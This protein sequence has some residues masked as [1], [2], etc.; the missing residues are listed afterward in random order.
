MIANRS[1]KWNAE[2]IA[3]IHDAP[4]SMGQTIGSLSKRHT[5]DIMELEARIKSLIAENKVM[6]FSK[7]YCPY[8]HKAKEAISKF[9]TDFTVLEVCTVYVMLQHCYFLS[10][11]SLA[12]LV[13]HLYAMQIYNDTRF[14]Q[15]FPAIQSLRVLR[16]MPC[17]A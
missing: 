10:S 14:H 11:G 17:A 8:C 4:A 6:V 7:S 2:R 5:S 15:L 1:Y 3:T 9:T 13:Y 16:S 12:L